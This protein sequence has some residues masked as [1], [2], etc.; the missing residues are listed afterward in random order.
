MDPR[1]PTNNS[2]G[3]PIPNNPQNN[4]L[5]SQMN[6]FGPNGHIP[7]MQ[8]P[9]RPQNFQTS[10]RMGRNVAAVGPMTGKMHP[11]VNMANRCNHSPNLQEAMVE[12]APDSMVPVQNPSMVHNI[13]ISGDPMQGA[14]QRGVPVYQHPQGP[15]IPG[16]NARPPMYNSMAMDLMQQQSKLH[17]V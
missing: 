17:L 11:V 6:K 12:Y 1:I 5:Q 16:Q 15:M 9:T 8:H 4:Y 7:Y 14:Y 13:S 2:N 3:L 10:P